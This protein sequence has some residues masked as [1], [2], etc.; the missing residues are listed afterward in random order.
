MVGG[1]FGG[2]IASYLHDVLHIPVGSYK[3]YY[4]FG[5]V[6]WIVAGVGSIVMLVGIILLIIGWRRIS[7]W[8]KSLEEPLEEMEAFEDEEVLAED[9]DEIV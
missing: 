5:W 9:I 1:F 6:N 4:E 3:A 8:R 7:K 2:P